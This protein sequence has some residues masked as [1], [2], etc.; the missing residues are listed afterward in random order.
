M[1]SKL[2]FFFAFVYHGIMDDKPGNSLAHFLDA[3]PR[4]G[5]SGSGVRS[6]NA[7]RTHCRA[8]YQEVKEEWE[9]K[10]SAPDDFERRELDLARRELELERRELSFLKRSSMTSGDKSA[11]DSVGD[12]LAEHKGTPLHENG[13]HC[14]PTVNPPGFRQPTPEKK[15]ASEIQDLIGALFTM[16]SSINRAQTGPL[17]PNDLFAGD[18]LNYKQFIRYFE[19]YTIRDVLNSATRLNLLIASCTGDAKDC[20]KN[21][22]MCESPDIGYWEARRILEENYGQMSGIVNAY[23]SKLTDGPTIKS[24]DSDAI[25]KLA[26]DL[27][28]CEITCRDR[29]NS[30][31]DTQQTIGKIFARLP[32]SLQDKFLSSVSYQ[33]EKGEPITFSQLSQFMQRHSCVERSYLTQIAKGRPDRQFASNTMFKKP[34][35]RYTVHSTQ[36]R[37][38]YSSST[39]TNY[40]YPQRVQPAEGQVDSAKHCPV[41]A[42]NHPLWRCSSFAEKSLNDRWD[43]I[44]KHGCC[45]NCFGDHLVRQCQSERRCRVCNGKHHTLLH[46]DRVQKKTVSSEET[47]DNRSNGAG[48]NTHSVQCDACDLNERTKSDSE[49]CSVVT[50]GINYVEKGTRI[51][52]RLKVLPVSVWHPGSDRIVSTYAFLDEGSNSTLCTESLIKR[53]GITGQRVK[54]AMS[55]VG[56]TSERWG[57]RTSLSFKGINECDQVNVSNVLAVSSLPDL[58]HSVPSREDAKRYSYLRDIDFPSLEY[59]QVDLLVGADVQMAHIPKE[60]RQRNSDEPTAVHTG[61]GWTLVGPEPLISENDLVSPPLINFVEVDNEVLHQQMLRAYN[62]DFPNER[63]GVGLSVEDRKALTVME[64][65]V[66]FNEGHYT[67]SLPWKSDAIVLPNNRSV[68]ERRVLNLRRRLIDDHEFSLKYRAKINEYLENGYARRVVEPESAASC[69]TW[70]LPHHATGDKFRIV[71]DC[72]ATYKGTSLNENL[73]QG[74]DHTNNLIGVLLRFREGSIGVVADIRSM[75]HQVRVDPDDYDSLRFL[76]WSTD[77]L[78]S[79]PQDFQMLVHLFGATSS[80]SCCSF[81]LKQVAKDNPLCVDSD[82]LHSIRRN[83]YVDDWLKS[84][85]RKAEAVGVIEQ[86]RLSL[87]YA[88]FHLTKFVS[89]EA[90]VLLGVP[91][92]DLSISMK[93]LDLDGVQGKALGLIWNASSDQ[94]GVKVKISSKP[95]TRR[96]ILSMV[97]QLYDPLGFVQPFLLPVKILLQGLCAAGLGWDD[98]IPPDR[99]D[100]WYQWLDSLHHLENLILKRC[101]WPIRFKPVLFELHCFC[102]ASCDGYSS[103]VY[104]RM[105]NEVGLVHCEFVLGRS[106]VTPLKTITIPRLELIAAVVGVDLVQFLKREMELSISRV[107]FWTDSTSVLCYVRNTTK[108]F[109][110]FVANR[111]AKILEGSN[112]SQW[113][114][115]DSK[116]NPA[117]IGSRGLMPDQTTKGEIWF[118][119]PPFLRKEESFWPALSKVLPELVDSDPEV[120]GVHAC[121]TQAS[122][123]KD[124]AVDRLLHHFSS[125]PKLLKSVVF[126]TR[127]GLYLHQKFVTHSVDVPTLK[128]PLSTLD[129]ETA[130]NS[131][132]RHVQSRSFSAELKL[133]SN[134]DTFVYNT[135]PL[136]NVSLKSSSIRNL[137][138]YLVHGLLRVGG[139]LQKSA[140]PEEAKHPI[141]MPTRHHV[142]DLIIKD[143]HEKNAHSGVLH[144]LSDSRDKFW[145]VN[146]NANVRRVLR[147]C[148]KCKVFNAVPGQQ[149]MAPLPK[150]RVTA[151]RPAFSCVGVDYAGPVFAKVGRSLAKRYFCVFSCLTSRAVHIEI[152]YSLDTQS[153]LQAIQRFVNRRG[154]PEEVY[155]DNGGNFVGASTELKDGVARWNQRVIHESLARKGINWNFN[156][157][158]ASHHGG[159]W[160]RMIRSV[161][162]LMMALS[163]ERALDENLITFATEVEKIL[164]DRPITPLNNDPSD[165]EAISPSMLLTGNLRVDVPTCEFLKAEAYRN[166]WKLVRWLADRFWQRWMKSYLPLLQRRQKWILPSRDLKKG[167]LV[168]V[169]DEHTRRG[170]WPK[171]IVEET[172]PGPDGRVRVARVRT[173]NNTFKRDVRKLCLLEAAD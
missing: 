132:V 168:L 39:K 17:H 62:H 41:C 87:D 95:Y 12:T 99:K 165:L 156:P 15:P 124:D 5:P 153:C 13:S 122:L 1:A 56:N 21:C 118:K 45:I 63:G 35:S 110:V 104:L 170:M 92:E 7:I 89:S 44:W 54:Y 86:I 29:R 31:L 147:D 171:A 133:L 109:H 65:T 71:F 142:T 70:Y 38:A 24:G 111:V 121:S 55:T 128:K 144:T 46:R 103:V 159:C 149:I 138:P 69:R 123:P 16:T 169:Y 85:N 164:N 25:L 14:H 146:G 64:R 163:C 58:R 100:L 172:F 37:P 97:S 47:P 76:W 148:S 72:G 93:D 36:N 136:S 131:V 80:P 106:R 107:V 91:E 141:I 130:L 77:D 139:R 11:S 90:E 137:N 126:L 173:V 10:N 27:Q 82:V 57:K 30:G 19:A 155:S 40:T 75:F 8:L 51:R 73:M 4:A 22:I 49:D 162:K 79:P 81:A 23:I 67:I 112:S 61:L 157:P 83:F 160:E 96:G 158:A 52:V 134:Q 53:L 101:Y 59:E 3:S 135:D 150:F 26:R 119:G 116:N 143:Y 84:F 114:Y 125:L 151:G 115:V 166:S 152:A 28:N 9:A 78:H 167:D 117:D 105:V 33:L 66:K 48:V 94:F 68:A 18:P 161:R 74:P 34:S 43:V 127:L 113:R 120:M 102:D 20:I 98:D 6:E 32:R 145:I 42:Q 2:P 129:L 140:L 154:P 50:S 108:R 88:G 60:V